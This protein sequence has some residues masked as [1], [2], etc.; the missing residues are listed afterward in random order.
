MFFK[1][2]PT[3]DGAKG[4]LLQECPHSKSVIECLKTGNFTNLKKN[5]HDTHHRGEKRKNARCVFRETKC[6]LIGREAGILLFT[7]ATV[8]KKVR[9][10]KFCTHCDCRQQ[11]EETLG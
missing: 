7:T 6:P 10:I 2:A 4:N 1:E 5:P 11:L 8:T 3:Q 9:H